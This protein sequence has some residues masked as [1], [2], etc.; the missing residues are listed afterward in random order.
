MKKEF[1]ME[2]QLLIGAGGVLFTMI[3]VVWAMLNAKINKIETKAEN[4][5]SQKTFD[6]YARRQDE[7][8]KELWE[9][10]D[11]LDEGQRDIERMIAANH[12]QLTQMLNESLVN[13]IRLHTKG[14]DK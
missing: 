9:K 8:K 11:R 2:Q 3:G 12:Q 7:A 1:G 13:M 14:V 5:V 10:F 4:A 6:E